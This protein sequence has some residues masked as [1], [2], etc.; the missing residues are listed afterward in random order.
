MWQAVYEE[1]KSEGLEIIAIA[2]DTAGKAA[3]EA[4][5]R[6]ADCAERP[7]ILARLMGWSADLWAR[8][9]PPTYPC[10]IDEAHIVA[11][12]YGIVNVPQAVW[13]DERGHLVR[14]PESAGTCDMVRS[15]DRTTFEVPDDAAERGVALRD[16]Y[17]DALRD[18]V[19]NGAASQYVLSPAEVRKRLR[20]PDEADVRAATHVRLGHYL[21][22]KGALERAKHH[23][24]E[25]VRLCPDKWNYRRQSNVSTRRKSVS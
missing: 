20:G 13:I 6:A 21:Y 17:I 22:G 4:R 10:L 8:Q 9:S 3:V 2:F 7:A 1:L 11:E 15:M 25:A 24:K 18:W 12:L 5:I 14:P 23:F 16:G 19:R